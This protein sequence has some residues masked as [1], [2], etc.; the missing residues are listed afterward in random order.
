MQPS[1][2]QDHPTTSRPRPVARTAQPA[3][4][5]ARH[6]YNRS[7]AL[8]AIHTTGHPCSKPPAQPAISTSSRRRAATCRHS[9]AS[10]PRRGRQPYSKKILRRPSQ[11]TRPDAARRR[12]PWRR[13]DELGRAAGVR[14][15][16]PSICR[17]TPSPAWTGRAA[18]RKPL[19]LRTRG[20]AQ[21]PSRPMRVAGDFIPIECF[22]PLWR[23]DWAAEVPHFRGSGRFAWLRELVSWELRI[24][25]CPSQPRIRTF[26]S[27]RVGGRPV[28]KRTVLGLA[29][30]RTCQAALA[31]SAGLPRH[32]RATP[33]NPC[34]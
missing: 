5:T 15:T 17:P 14:G 27:F 11:P 13:G 4:R 2:Q 33:A 28:A 21:S 7:S 24:S 19:A 34:N 3:A 32:A 12:R 10:P 6:P 26:R 29:D 8:P 31:Q 25:T 18:S 16:L 9:A 30:R 20:Q 1:R 23:S 22:I